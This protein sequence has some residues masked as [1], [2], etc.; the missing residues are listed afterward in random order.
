VKKEGQLTT[1]TLIKAEV[2]QI[3]LILEEQKKKIINRHK[4]K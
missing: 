1:L 4:W 3:E 2:M